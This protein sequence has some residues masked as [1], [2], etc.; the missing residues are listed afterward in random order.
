MTPTPTGI[1]EHRPDG[2]TDLV[3]GRRT[4]EA[5][6]TVWTQLTEPERTAAWFG[7]WRGER[8]PGAVIEVQMGFEE[9]DHWVEAR[10]I[11]CNPE[12][13]FVVSTSDDAGSWNLEIELIDHGDEREV[14]LIHHLSSVDGIGEIGPGWEFYLDLFS[15]SLTGA[16]RPTFDAY[17]PG[18]KEYFEKLV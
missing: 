15:A 16:D 14:R 2:T 7:P 10:I 13:G 18:M 11:S 8:R 9:G 1:L 4:T 5:V 3:V 6:E 12:R 17:Y